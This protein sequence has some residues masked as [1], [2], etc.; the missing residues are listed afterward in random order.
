MGIAELLANEVASREDYMCFNTHVE[1]A[2][3]RVQ[4]SLSKVVTSDKDP[5]MAV[6]HNVEQD[7]RGHSRRDKQQT[8]NLKL[9]VSQ[10]LTFRLH[11]SSFL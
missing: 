8:L 5:I 11:I 1:Q 9:V 2:Y 7:K 6:G 3:G 10:L 4:P